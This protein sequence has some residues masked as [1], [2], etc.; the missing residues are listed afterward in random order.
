MAATVVI[1][2]SNGKTPTITHVTNCN[3][4]STDAVNLVAAS[5]PITAGGRSYEK[6]WRLHVHD[7]STS[8]SISTVKFWISGFTG[9]AD[10]DWYT[11]ARTSGYEGAQTFD[12]TNGPA[13]TD[14]SATYD[15]TQAV[16]TSEP[17]SA[18]VGIGGAL[19][20]TLTTSDSYSDYCIV[21]VAVDASTVAGGSATVNMKYTEVA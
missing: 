21:Q 20:G 14:R 6:W 19:D 9:D 12:T 8:S 17:A 5:Y 11:N 18:N 16:P 7:I 4:G 3:L 15:Y 10:D 1:A 13:A 2:E